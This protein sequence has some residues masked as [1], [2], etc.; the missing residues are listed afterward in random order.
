MAIN[1]DKRGVELRERS[2]YAAW[3]WIT[4][5]W[6]P[7]GEGCEDAEERVSVEVRS[8]E[9][10]PAGGAGGGNPVGRSLTA[11][12]MGYAD[13][14]FYERNT[15]GSFD[16]G[17]ENR[18]PAKSVRAWFCA[19]GSRHFRQRKKRVCGRNCHALHHIGRWAISARH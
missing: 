1:L 14:Y 2:W 19:H 7:G 6:W 13:G 8:S 15:G 18:R 17:L 12:R 10:R 9:A 3:A 5:R 11:M 4:A 16:T